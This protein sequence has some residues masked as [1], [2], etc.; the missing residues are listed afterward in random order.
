MKLQFN[1][2]YFTN[3][4]EQLE[5]CVLGDEKSQPHAMT[6]LDGH[7]WILD[8]NGDALR[9]KNKAYVDYYYRV[10]IDKNGSFVRTDLS[11]L[12]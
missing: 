2:E 7:N 3:Y 5:L 6:T 9:G 10:C 4:G 1:L 11:L 8:I 12:L